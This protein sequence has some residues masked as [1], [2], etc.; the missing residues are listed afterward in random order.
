MNNRAHENRKIRL[1]EL[2][3]TLLKDVDKVYDIWKN[4]EN[5]EVKEYF[6]QVLFTLNKLLYELN[7]DLENNIYTD[8]MIEKS[9]EISDFLKQIFD[10]LNEE[11]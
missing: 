5:E 10:D 8:E 6:S 1:T 7:I 4:S 9:E 2:N 11:E 3:E